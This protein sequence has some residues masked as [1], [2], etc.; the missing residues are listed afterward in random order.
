MPMRPRHS[1]A[2]IAERCYKW[3][4][5]D[6]YRPIRLEMELENYGDFCYQNWTHGYAVA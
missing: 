3:P 5:L 2:S 1:S 6:L 4:A